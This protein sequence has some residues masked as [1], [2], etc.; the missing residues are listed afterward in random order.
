MK[1]D[2]NKKYK[3]FYTSVSNKIIEEKR[4]L[5]V[6]EQ[7]PGLPCDRRVTGGDTYHYTN[8]DYIIQMQNL[9]YIKKL[10]L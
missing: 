8:E 9:Y 2:A 4:Y 7:N 6:G 1:T 3:A 10:I 5:P